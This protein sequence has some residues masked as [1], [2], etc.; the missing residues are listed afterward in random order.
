MT[1]EILIKARALIAD[2]EHWIKEDY[3]QDINHNSLNY[4]DRGQ[5]AKCFC[6]IGALIYA[7]NTTDDKVRITELDNLIIPHIPKEFKGGCDYYASIVAFN[8]DPSTTH[9]DV[10]AVL[11]QAIGAL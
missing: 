1:K 5:E 11:D 6:F 10:L 2:P 8:D 9:S 4:T 7:R 3:I